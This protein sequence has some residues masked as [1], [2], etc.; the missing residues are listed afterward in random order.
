VLLLLLPLGWQRQSHLPALK[1]LA[2]AWAL[3][4]LLLLLEWRLHWLLGLWWGPLALKRQQRRERMQRRAAGL[5][6]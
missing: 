6:A 3:L 1:P 2:P 5:Q 4:L